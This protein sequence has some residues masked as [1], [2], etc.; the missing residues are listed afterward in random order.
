MRARTFPRRRPTKMPRATRGTSLRVGFA[1]TAAEAGADIRSI[2]SVTRH[3]SLA[4]PARYAEKADQIRTSPHKVA[5]RRA[6]GIVRRVR[7]LAV[8]G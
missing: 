3:R 5:G 6:Q 2:A 7:P 8:G 1:V 4:M